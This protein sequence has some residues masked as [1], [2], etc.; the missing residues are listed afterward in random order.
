MQKQR[1]ELT[2]QYQ[3]DLQKATE[4]LQ[5]EGATSSAAGLRK[6]LL[7]FSQFLRCAA[8]KRGDEDVADTD[9]GRAFEGALLLV[10]GGDQKAVDAAM[11]LVDGTD[12]QVP[13][14]DGVPTPIKCKFMFAHSSDSVLLRAFRNARCRNVANVI[15]TLRSTRLQSNTLHSRPRRNGLTM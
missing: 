9:E 10:Y 13:G 5:L 12:E 1:D 4:D 14:I 6:K 2:A 7:V 3:K 11:N 8:H 15:Q